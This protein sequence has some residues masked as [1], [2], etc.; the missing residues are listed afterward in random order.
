MKKLLLYLFL[1]LSLSANAQISKAKMFFFLT[2]QASTPAEDVPE[3]SVSPV[4][5]GTALWSNTLTT[6]NG[7]WTNSPTSYTYQWYRDASPIGSA[8]ASTYVT[9]LADL[10][11]DVTCQ[12]TA[13][14]SEGS[15]TPSASNAITVTTTAANF[16]HT[17][18]TV[19]DGSANAFVYAPLHLHNPPDGGWPVIIAFQGDGT[20]NN[21]TRTFT[22]V[23]MSTGDNLTYTHSPAAA[24]YRIMCSS[25][26]I[27]V[28][29]VEVARGYPGGTIT[30]T[31]VTGTI[32]SFDIDDAN[33]NTSPTVSVTFNSSQS[34]NTIT[35]DYVDSTML[36]EG[37][38]R[39]MNLGDNLDD[40]TVYIAIQNVNST[41]DFERDYWDNSVT[42]AWN[43]FT[44]N[45]NRIHAAGIS[46][47]GRQ[48]VDQF[49]NGSN[50]SVLKTRYQFWILR[51]DGSIVTSD[52]SNETTHATSGLASLVCGTTSYGG[53]FTAANYT[54]IGMAIV[55]GTSDG[56]LTNT[57]YTYA[58]T[59]AS[60]N[61]PPFILNISG[62][63][64]NKD[65]WDGKCYKRLY[66][67]GISSGSLTTADWDWVDFLLKYSKNATERATLFV[68][69]AEKRRYGTEKDIIDY[70]HAL[71]QVNALSSSAEKTA[72]LARLSSLKT[73]IDNGGTRWVV[74]FHSAGE[75]ESS[76]YNN[77]A[78]ATAG[79]T[80]SNIVDFDGN[81]STLDIELDT[82]PGGGLAAIAST[83][84]SFTGGFS[85]T[86]N[87][88]G[89]ILTGFPFGTFK[90]TGVPAGTYTVR[91]YHN[92]G[93]SNFSSDPR[94][95]ITIDGV[96]KSGYSAINTLIGY[97]EF[98]GLDAADLAQFDTSYDTSA[99]TN[100]TI[101][102]IF[103]H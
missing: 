8:T 73:S 67:V 57:S 5:S 15:S 42:Y 64:H 33:T 90:F 93:V 26:R 68:E 30:G 61:E 29:G 77:F 19:S 24:L 65:V 40:R 14:N 16:Y 62:G 59:M 101:M 12:V 20:S 27:K 49:S 9:V 37:S 1:A 99:N 63:F 45:P 23:A 88:S 51:S 21:T 66:R 60:N 48:I 38:P 95:R 58:T 6:T 100:L 17:N 81:S 74:N 47:G 7:T 2:Q 43:N 28:N 34:G 44:I 86:A 13:I 56:T 18:I 31:G 102:E 96:T 84:R 39:W 92:V 35:Y 83:R 71:R 25:I 80:I 94:I 52:P 53:S 46:R 32:S 69:Q 70:R 55:H 78:S 36:A 79:T 50:T 82:D 87:N 41:A 72:L 91:F 75:S 103:K 10:D 54:N 3:I 85:K 11:A 76:P 97:V 98:T 4:I 89:L 22:A